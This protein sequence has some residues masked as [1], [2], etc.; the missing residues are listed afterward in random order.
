MK[1]IFF[2]VCVVFSLY[3]ANSLQA[4]KSPLIHESIHA[5]YAQAASVSLSQTSAKDLFQVQMVIQGKGLKVGNN[6][7]E[8][9][10]LD[11]NEKEVS[12]SQITVLPVLYRH[13]E[14]MLVKPT[15]ID[16]GEGRYMVE[17]LYFDMVGHWE[18]RIKIRKGEIEDVAIF[19]FPEIKREG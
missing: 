11:K 16:K 19:D 15:V 3:T 18:I 6:R 9:V 13:G 5:R 17:N 8:L 2:I 4:A 14:G 12:G 10:L 7:V 1:P